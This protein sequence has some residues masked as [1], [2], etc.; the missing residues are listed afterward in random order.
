MSPYSSTE[1]YTLP[2]VILTSDI[3]W[4]PS[5]IDSTKPKYDSWF[6]TVLDSSKLESCGPFDMHGYYV[7]R[8]IVEDYEL[9]YFY[10]KNM[11]GIMNSQL[12]VVFY[13]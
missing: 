5:V 10:A 4:Y 12:T 11:M 9:Y 2:H 7:G 1:L 13:M 3:D 6:D 8:T